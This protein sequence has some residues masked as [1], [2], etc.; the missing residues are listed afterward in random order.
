MYNFH[1]Q[2]TDLLKLETGLLI[3]HGR[4]RLKKKKY[5]LNR[6]IQLCCTIFLCNNIYLKVLYLVDIIL[7]KSLF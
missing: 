3:C 6:I 7:I 5:N 2:Q 4:L 1:G